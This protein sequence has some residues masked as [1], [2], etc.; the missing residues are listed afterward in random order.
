MRRL[1]ALALLPVLL[2]GCVTAVVGAATETGL[3]LAEN[4]SLG[5]KVDD[6]V[7]YTDLTN[8]FVGSD[9]AKL[10]TYVSFNIR[11]GRVMLTGIVPSQ[12]EADK[13]VALSWKA[14]GVLE[15]INEL[16]V[17]P[18][19][20]YAAIA[21]DSLTKRNLEARLLF[22]KD[23]WVINYSLDV[24]EGTAFIIGRVK[25]DAELSRVMNV[26]RTTRGVKRVVNHLQVNADTQNGTEAPPASNLT[27]PAS[28]ATVV[29]PN[30]P[31]DSKS[32]YIPPVTP[33]GGY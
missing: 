27:Q 30:D 23:V 19:R 18:D 14:K 9:N 11:Y 7:I 22:T 21:E 2:S 33:G 17:R 5:R 32:N 29:Q 3:S 28:N 13:A 20:S 4:R 1:L 15:V 16:L 10:L 8:Q 12:A 25:D 6:T 26:A 24:T 31:I